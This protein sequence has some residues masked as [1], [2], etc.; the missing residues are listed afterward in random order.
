MVKKF[1]QDTYPEFVIVEDATINTFAFRTKK[2]LGVY[3][4]VKVPDP[5]TYGHAIHVGVRARMRLSNGEIKDYNVY[6][7]EKLGTGKFQTAIIQR[8]KNWQKRVA[9]EINNGLEE[10]RSKYYKDIYFKSNGY[11]F[12]YKRDFPD[13]N[14]EN[15]L[16]FFAWLKYHTENNLKLE[17]DEFNTT[18]LNYMAKNKDFFNSTGLG[19]NL[20]SYTRDEI[21]Q[22]IYDTDKN[23]N[24]SSIYDYMVK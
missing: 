24:G 14:F 18:L 23:L 13:A 17:K 20:N 12:K 7:R 9:E 3:L 19:D 8:S 5:E 16:N 15:E 2:K 6:P 1:I 22:I 4:S 10:Y 11:T 21:F